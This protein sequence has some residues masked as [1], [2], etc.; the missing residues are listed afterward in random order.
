VKVDGR[1]HCGRIRFEGDVDPASVG[2][3]HCSDCQT[4]TGSAFRATVR[5]PAASFRLSG[6]PRTYVK[7]A[8]SGNRRVHAFC[9]D[10]G[11]PIYAAP[12]E[13]PDSYSLRVG[14]LRQRAE[15]FPP[16]VQIWCDSA[17]P[18]AFDLRDID[19]RSKQ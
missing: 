6:A 5:T 19:R 7:T 9:G 17:L 3:C 2:L 18:W 8:D 12:V 4:L 1:C 16:R 10:C 11:T 15:L 13:N 14:T